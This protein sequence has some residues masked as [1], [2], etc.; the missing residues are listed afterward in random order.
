MQ[1]VEDMLAANQVFLVL[2]L[3]FFVGAL[4]AWSTDFEGAL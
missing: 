3:V 2:G 4:M 1:L